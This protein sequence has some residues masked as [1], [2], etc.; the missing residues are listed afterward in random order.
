MQRY[1]S[2]SFM[3]RFEANE[4]IIFSSSTSSPRN[5]VV[6]EWKIGFAVFF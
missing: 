5:E 2:R 1:V 6:H 3:L 4:Y